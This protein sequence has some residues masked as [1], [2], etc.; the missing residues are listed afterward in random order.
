[1][2]ELIERRDLQSEAIGRFLEAARKLNCCSELL[3]KN[4]SANQAPN[5]SLKL[6]AR[7]LVLPTS[8]LD[9]Q[10][11]IV[12]SLTGEKSGLRYFGVEAGSPAHLIS[13]PLKR[14]KAHSLNFIF[15][16]LAFQCID[17]NAHRANIAQPF[18]P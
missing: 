7:C 17:L 13:D 18:D 9:Q 8:L 3:R 11:V 15:G 1:M 4:Q 10:T 2:V 14:R 5:T 12:F 6:F 16:G